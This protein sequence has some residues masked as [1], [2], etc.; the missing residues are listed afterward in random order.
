MTRENSVELQTRTTDG[1]ELGLGAVLYND[2]YDAPEDRRDLWHVTARFED[3]DSGSRIYELWDGT[4]TSRLYYTA[5]D[6]LVDFAPAG[7][8]FPTA[9]KPTYFLTREIGAPDPTDK[10]TFD[11][12]WSEA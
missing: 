7:W 6:V 4:H 12:Y 1:W 10:M 2:R 11:D 9:R 3:V 8:Q 5:E